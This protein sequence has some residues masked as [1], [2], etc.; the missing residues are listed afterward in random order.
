MRTNI[1]PTGQADIER[2][3]ADPDANPVELSSALIDHHIRRGRVMRSRAAA[4]LLRDAGRGLKRLFGGS[5]R[6]GHGHGHL[7]PSNV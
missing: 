3:Y 1:R 4:D 5:D 2:L 7:K 6:R